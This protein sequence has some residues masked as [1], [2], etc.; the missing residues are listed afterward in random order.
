MIYYA[1]RQSLFVGLRF[2]QN[3]PS[4]SHLF[5]ADNSII[6]CKASFEHATSIRKV[7]QDFVAISGHEVN[8]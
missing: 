1:E 2:N 8:F 4:I 7:L 5:F 6:F 3:S